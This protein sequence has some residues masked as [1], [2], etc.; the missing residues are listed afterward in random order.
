[1]SGPVSVSPAP[2]AGNGGQVSTQPADSYEV[3]AVIDI[4]HPSDS[5]TLQSYVVCG[6]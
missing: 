2:P 4:L 1:L 5:V 3:Q 6:P